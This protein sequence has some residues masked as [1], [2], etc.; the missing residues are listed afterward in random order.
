M[1]QFASSFRE[2]ESQLAGNI[3]YGRA[4]QPFRNEPKTWTCELNI[5]ST[6][7][8]V[9]RLRWAPRGISAKLGA[10]QFASPFSWECCVLCFMPVYPGAR[11]VI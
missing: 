10:E 8:R 4:R 5:E 2:C 11:V 9:F 7:T 1:N 3:D 6:Y